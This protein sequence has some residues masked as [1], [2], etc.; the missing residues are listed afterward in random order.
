MA[1]LVG[2]GKDHVDLVHSFA[3]YGEVLVWIVAACRRSQWRTL[4]TYWICPIQPEA[5]VCEGLLCAAL[6]A[7]AEGLGFGGGWRSLGQKQAPP[8]HWI[9]RS[10]RLVAERIAGEG[11]SSPMAR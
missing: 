10:R 4:R 3:D 7:C 9:G 11:T 8:E 6:G 2:D 5:A 1:T